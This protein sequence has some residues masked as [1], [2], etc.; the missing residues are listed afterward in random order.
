MVIILKKFTVQWGKEKQVCSGFEGFED[1][2]EEMKIE[3]SVEG[4]DRHLTRQCLG[5]RGC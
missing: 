1:F 4:Q 2:S 5:K 3:P